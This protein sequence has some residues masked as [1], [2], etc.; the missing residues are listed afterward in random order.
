MTARWSL[1]LFRSVPL[2][3]MTTSA[4]PPGASGQ[5]CDAYD[6]PQRDFSFRSLGSTSSCERLQQSWDE[7]SSIIKHINALTSSIN[8]DRLSNGQHHLY[9]CCQPATYNMLI[10][11][12]GLS[13]QHGAQAWTQKPDYKTYQ[14][15]YGPAYNFIVGPYLVLVL[16]TYSGTPSTRI[17]MA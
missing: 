11:S 2:F 7:S 6:W 3:V 1:P 5:A 13:G 12:Q 8:T 16:I 14:S 15:P 10:I 17:S 4:L 9:S